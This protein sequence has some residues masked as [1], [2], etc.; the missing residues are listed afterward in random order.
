MKETPDDKRKK[1]T[2]E[3]KL[4]NKKTQES[5][6]GQRESF[7]RKQDSNLAMLVCIPHTHIVLH[8]KLTK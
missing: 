1:G 7:T 8:I 3:H 6:L 2:D 4:V 5:M